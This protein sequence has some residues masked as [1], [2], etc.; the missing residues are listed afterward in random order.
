MKQHLGA[1]ALVVPSYEEG[2]RFY[3]DLLGFTVVEDTALAGD[4]RWLLLAPPGSSE[5]RL[6]LSRAETDAQRQAIGAQAG[7]RVF[8]FLHTDDF[9]RDHRRYLNAGVEFLE[10]P[11]EEAYGIVAVFRDPF[12]NTW[13]LIERRQP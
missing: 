9:R 1:V 6:L 8:L 2:L 4:R 10:H 13:D 12:G 3:A 5:T 11:R 7:G